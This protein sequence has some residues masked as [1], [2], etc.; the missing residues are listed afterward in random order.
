MTPLLPIPPGR[1]APGSTDAPFRP[2]LRL[3]ELPPGA[4]RRVTFGD[5][6]VLLAHADRGIAAIPDRCP[7]QAAPLSLGSIDGCRVICPLHDAVFDLATGEPVVMPTS[8]GLTPDGATDPGWTPPGRE[9]KEDR[10]GIRTNARRLTRVQRLRY[11]PIRIEG[12][13]I[14]IAVPD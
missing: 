3:D 8:G 1:H 4:L 10:P 7:H 12:G 6:D 9:P 5:T 2:A 14:S 11:F 13:V